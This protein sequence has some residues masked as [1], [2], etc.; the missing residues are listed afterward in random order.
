MRAIP[1]LMLRTPTAVASLVGT[2]HSR[3]VPRLPIGIA[4]Y[5]RWVIGLLA[6][7]HVVIVVIVP[8]MPLVLSLRVEILSL[9][10][11]SADSHAAH[12]SIHFSPSLHFPHSQR[13]HTGPH[14]RHTAAVTSSP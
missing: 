12:C 9:I 4:Y 3:I 11:H 7:V 14:R 6:P 1:H 5:S 13:C 10:T 2:T 8:K